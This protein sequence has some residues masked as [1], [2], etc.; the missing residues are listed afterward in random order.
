MLVDNRLRNILW[1]VV[2]TPRNK[3]SISWHL[4]VKQTQANSKLEE[5]LNVIDSTLPVTV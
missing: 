3:R 1:A 5:V 2:K 4:S